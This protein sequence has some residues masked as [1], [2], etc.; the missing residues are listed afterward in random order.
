MFAVCCFAGSKFLVVEKE[1]QVLSDEFR[2]D[3]FRRGAVGIT[4]GF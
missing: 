4:S 2:S 1:D 3:E